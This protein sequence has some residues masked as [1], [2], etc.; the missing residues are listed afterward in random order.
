MVKINF[1]VNQLGSVPSNAVLE[2]SRYFKRMIKK[3]TQLEFK[4]GIE[5]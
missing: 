4:V 2:D 3:K 5:M 1:G